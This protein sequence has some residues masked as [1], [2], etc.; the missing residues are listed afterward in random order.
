MRPQSSV[1]K[2]IYHFSNNTTLLKIR[3]SKTSHYIIMGIIFSFNTSDTRKFDFVS[4]HQNAVQ[5]LG[6]KIRHFPFVSMFFPTPVFNLA[7]LPLSV[8]VHGNK[9]DAFRYKRFTFPGCLP[10]NGI[11]KHFILPTLKVQSAI[12]WH[13]L[14]FMS[15]SRL[16]ILLFKVCFT[17]F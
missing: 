13:L 3:N 17:F 9:L 15:K 1:P 16:N 12:L 14:H 2:C 6:P 11:K 10:L 5:N 4:C 8:Y 7:Y